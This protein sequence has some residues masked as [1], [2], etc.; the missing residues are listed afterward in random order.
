MPARNLLENLPIRHKLRVI[1]LVISGLSV[2]GS[3][4]VF[5]A[6]DRVSYRA[7]L[8]RQLEILAEIVGDQAA[9]AIEFDQPKQAVAILASLKA[10]RQL[11]AAAIYTPD[12]RLFADYLREGAD[13]RAIPERPGPPGRSFAAGQVSLSHP[14]RS[15]G[16]EV[17]TFYL[18]SDLSEARRRLL[19]DLAIVALVLLA[20]TAAIL[21]LSGKLGGILTEPILGLCD[22]AQAVSKERN[23]SVRAKGA[24]RD[25]LGR[26][27]AGF[28]DMLA[29]IEARDVALARARDE[30]EQRVEERTRALQAAK[31]EMEA[32]SYSISHDLRAPLRSIDGFSQMLVKNHTAQ[33]DEEGRRLFGIVRENTQRMGEMIDALLH[34]SRLERESV[35][36]TPVDMRDLVGEVVKELRALE[37]G[38]DV[39]VEVGPLPVVSGDRALLRQVWQNLVAN[40]LKYSRSRDRAIIRI[41]SERSPEGAVFH[42]RD[43]GVGFDMKYAGKLFGTFQRLHTR[44]EFEG[45]GIGLA[46]VQRVVSRHGGRVWAEAELDKGA[47]FHFTIPPRETAAGGEESS[48]H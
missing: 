38:R 31:E 22:V 35:A 23:Y 34:L 33:L 44:D 12:G 10:E 1:I 2:V 19:L 27:I 24:G 43:N 29:E 6:Q 32:F 21:Y 18:C 30:L 20:A 14:L 36:R 16:D 11:V 45:T 15:G 39:E 25:E 47:K 42:V 8:T 5:L 13:R 41:G 48:Q 40:A 37:A 17:G 4:A 46:I 28:N 26:L 3:C 7:A 9:P